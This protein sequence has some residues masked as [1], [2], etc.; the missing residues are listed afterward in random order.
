M[1]T[2]KHLDANAIIIML[3]LCICWGLQQVAVKLATPVI[4]AGLQLGL[5]SE[6]AAML[7][8]ALIWWK[9]I[10]F[11]LRDRHLLPGL[12]AGLFFALEF[13]C[14]SYG[15]N[16]TTASHMSV[17]L[18]T[19]P[20]FTV[21]GLHLLIP[22]ER[23]HARQ[24]LGVASAFGGI[25]IAFSGA[26]QNSADDIRQMLIGDSLGVLAALLWAATT[27]TIRFSSLADAEPTT[28]LFYQLAGAAVILTGVVLLRGEVW[29]AWTAVAWV[30][31]LFQSV[32]VAFASYLAWFW[33]MRHYLVS[34]LSV[35][36]FL[37]PLFG[38]AAGVLLMHDVISSRFAIGALMVLGGIV[39]VNFKKN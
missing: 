2:R 6:I 25:A 39:L 9:K 20:I 3:L 24:W 17:F 13:L 31:M 30:S 33:L 7:V 26:M 27:L 21:I 19:A 11:S 22:S 14:V 34:R 35:F 28:T 10:P 12:I 36:S 38:V 8:L 18:Y 32:I 5:R 15:L 37:T 1:T 4:S 23:L 29:H 16:F